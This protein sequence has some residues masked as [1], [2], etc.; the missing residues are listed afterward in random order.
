[1]ALFT[2]DDFTAAVP[3]A[4]QLLALDDDA[5]G[6]Q[7]TGLFDKLIAAATTWIEGFLDQAGLELGDPPHAR[8]KH[9]GLKYGEYELWRRRGHHERAKDIYEQWIAPGEK[10]LSKIA[11]GQESL[12]PPT[13]AT[14]DTDQAGVI[15]E[16]AKT[17]EDGGRLLA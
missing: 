8:L 11:T 2:Q 17:Y 1:M 9:Y 6:T 14:G 16:D 10:W 3:E 5:D 13:E 7:D 15:T 12:T 4:F